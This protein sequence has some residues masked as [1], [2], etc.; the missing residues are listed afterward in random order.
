MARHACYNVHQRP[1]YRVR[2][3]AARFCATD[4][5]KNT[6]MGH[7]LTVSMAPAMAPAAPATIGFLLFL[8]APDMCGA[9]F[10]WNECARA[11]IRFLGLASEGR[12]RA[13]D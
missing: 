12:G 13:D 10:F 6:Y 3:R 4:K 1:G 5:Q 8:Q 7:T 11:K 9:D 2:P